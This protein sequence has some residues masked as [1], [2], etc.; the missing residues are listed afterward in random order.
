MGA[1]HKRPTR[2]VCICPLCPRK[3]TLAGVSSVSVKCQKRT[4]VSVCEC[5]QVAFPLLYLTRN[6][7][8]GCALLVL[9]IFIVFASRS[10]F[11]KSTIWIVWSSYDL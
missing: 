9:S 2:Y 3:R 11:F 7:T 5:R 10:N 8:M 4:F 6:I 1:F